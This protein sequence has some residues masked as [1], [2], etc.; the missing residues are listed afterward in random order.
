M[1][2]KPRHVLASVLVVLGAPASAMAA[3]TAPVNLSSAGVDAFNQQVAVDADG[4]AVFTW[5]NFNFLQIEGRARSTAGV[6]GP[7]Q[8]LSPAG[9]PA[10]SP[11]VAVDADGNAVFTWTRS[12]GTSFRAQARARSATGVLG[13][14]QTLS[15]AGINAYTP[16][17]AVDTDGDAV[18]GWENFGTRRIQARARAAAG[19]LSPIQ[20]LSAAGVGQLADFPKVAVDA[21]GDA[22][23]TWRQYNG[24][25]ILI[26]PARDRP[27][28][29]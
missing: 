11:Q 21:D 7:I 14:V 17:V 24:G 15:P 6:L 18:F 3:W 1:I 29:S 5:R 26:R 8:P 13:A 20:T 23:F 28:A 2:P 22:V 9:Q 12:D 16:Q 25:N 4:D 27:P 10:Q 19:A